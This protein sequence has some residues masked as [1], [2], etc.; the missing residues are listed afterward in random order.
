M[1]APTVTVTIDLS[2]MIG[3]AVADV[4]ITAKLDKTEVYGGFIVAGT[5]TATTDDNGVATMELFPNAL[6]DADLPGLGTMGS[7]YRFTATATGGKKLDVQ[8]VIPNTDCNLH[9]VILAEDATAPN[10]GLLQ[11]SVRYDI[12]QTLT[13]PQQAQ[14]RANIGFVAA[15]LATA[16]TGLSA[17]SGGTIAA[18]DTV[19]QAFGKIE[20][21]LTDLEDGGISGPYT[22]T[23][24]SASP[25][26][27]LVN[28]G[29]GLALS[30]AGGITAGQ[31]TGPLTG[32]VTG[33]VSGSAG[34]VAAAN[35]TGTTMAANV[36]NAS[37][38]SITPSGGALGVAGSFNTSD[39]ITV[40]GSAGIVAGSGLELNGGATPS[41]L[42]YNRTG[43]AYL[44]LSL[45]GSTITL[46]PNDSGVLTASAGQVAVTGR[47]TIT[48]NSASPAFFVTQ[49]G[50][51]RVI[52]AS[53]GNGTNRVSITNGVDA[54]FNISFASLL[55]TVGTSSGDLALRAGGVDR[56]LL[57]STGAAVT[58]SISATDGISTAYATADGGTA[59]I[60]VRN[61]NTHP[62][63]LAAYKMQTDMSG[64]VWQMFA[65]NNSITWGVSGV[66]D[67]MSLTPSGLAVTGDASAS[68]VTA[69]SRVVTD[70]INARTTTRVSINNVSGTSIATFDHSTGLSSFNFGAAVTGSQTITN[71]GANTADIALIQTGTD[72]RTW[73]IG[74]TGSGYGA[75][76]K[77]IVFDVTGNV[78]RYSID[79]NGVHAVTGIQTI[80]A[81]TSSA[82]LSVTQNGAGN[83][84]NVAGNS[85]FSMDDGYLALRRSA[86][87]KAISL[88]YNTGGVDKWFYGMREL[89]ND[90]LSWYNYTTG[91]ERMTLSEAGALAVTGSISAT[92]PIS[93][94]GAYMQIETSFTPAGAG[95]TGATGQIVWDANYIYVCVATDTWKRSALSTW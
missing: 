70:D 10:P 43:G 91:T 25:T 17:G 45:R 92:G 13:S 66:A 42:G 52:E 6:P 12:A 76:G 88:V 31:F 30:T 54:D 2:S 41:V 85:Q 14:A 20:Y 5:T 84:L 94:D 71:S 87:N 61:T 1:A 9:S 27:T 49:N 32:N 53:T 50:G 57:S 56:V 35:L 74:S 83:A 90:T 16:L 24:N 34:S 18:T 95:A 22:I 86:T 77:Y 4:E 51:G 39:G 80:T 21:R 40:R 89:G 72:G 15:V 33:N 44:P 82:G 11:G 47:Q 36:V 68:V 28:N 63:S 26:L 37:L 38:N 23:A 75:P 67:Y 59:A 60:T 62:T 8:A 79:A 78:E 48:A 3:V 19:L 29:A 65:R 69:S 55:T 46:S 81:N 73:G 58:G 7:I 64:N 93:T